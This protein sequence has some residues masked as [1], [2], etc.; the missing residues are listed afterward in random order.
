MANYIVN[1]FWNERF[2]WFNSIIKF[3]LVLRM[4]K[5]K[6]VFL[7]SGGTLVDSQLRL[8]RGC[9]VWSRLAECL[10]MSKNVCFAS[11]WCGG[12]S[13]P[14]KSWDYAES[15]NKLLHSAAKLVVEKLWRKS[16]WKASVSYLEYS[17]TSCRSKSR[18]I[19][20]SVHFGSCWR[21]GMVEN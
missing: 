20:E 5:E 7:N 8:I 10:K 1:R 17:G 13:W 16:G 9:W 12:F 19:W 15:G 6:D 14:M 21:T 4:Y 2:R 3:L 18:V 11:L